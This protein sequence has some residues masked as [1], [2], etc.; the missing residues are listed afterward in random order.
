M[1]A[2]QTVLSDLAVGESNTF[3]QLTLFP[4]KA[5]KFPAR[6]YHT[7]DE[8][9]EARGIEI[10]EV[11]EGGSVPGRRRHLAQIIYLGLGSQRKVFHFI[12]D[13]GSRPESAL[14]ITEP[15]VK[16]VPFPYECVETAFR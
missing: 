6:D 16:S 11:S 15:P 12:F 2:I 10:S 1:K 3:G 8:A 4:L 9:L 13:T 14:D 7:F 5:S